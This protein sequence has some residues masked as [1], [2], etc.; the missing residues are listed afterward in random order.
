MIAV[1]IV[2]NVKVNKNQFNRT[3]PSGVEM[4]ESYGQKVKVQMFERFSK[5]FAMFLTLIGLILI[6]SHFVSY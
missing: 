5:F 2:I 6:V 1:A 4:F 3:N